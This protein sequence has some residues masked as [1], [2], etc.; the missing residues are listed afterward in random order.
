MIYRLLNETFA[1]TP[2]VIVEVYNEDL[3]FRGKQLPTNDKLHYHRLNLEW[4]TSSDLGDLM[5]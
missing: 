5:A 3:T 4:E 2:V 1:L